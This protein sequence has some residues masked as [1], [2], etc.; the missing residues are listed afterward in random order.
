MEEMTLDEWI[1]QGW[2]KGS[3]EKDHGCGDGVLVNLVENHLLHYA[4]PITRPKLEQF[5]QQYRKM[6][7]WY[8]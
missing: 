7:K 4:D 6:R 8:A 2:P 5:L 1:E 3:P